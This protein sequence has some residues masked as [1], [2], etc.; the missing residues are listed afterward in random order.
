MKQY[1]VLVLLGVLSVVCRLPLEEH[2]ITCSIF[3]VPPK[4]VVSVITHLYIT[5][6]P[7]PEQQGKLQDRWRNQVTLRPLGA[8]SSWPGD[9]PDYSCTSGLVSKTP[10]STFRCQLDGLRPSKSFKSQTF[11]EVFAMSA[12]WLLGVVLGAFFEPRAK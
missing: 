11:L 3:E 7:G 8:S 4:Y 5:R 10:Q 2:P 6:V 1:S 12:Q 9:S